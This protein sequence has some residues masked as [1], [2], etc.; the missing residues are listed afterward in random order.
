MTPTPATHPAPEL[1]IV[2]GGAK[3]V[4]RAVALALARAGLDV[5]ITYRSSRDDA[6][7]VVNDIEATG[8]RALAIELDLARP[9]AADT[10]A[11]AIAPL[12]ARVKALVNN[13]AI[14]SPTPL[15]E[16]DADAYD[17]FQALN[18]RAPL[19]LTQR[20]APLLAAGHDPD[21]PATA[22]R[23]V[24]FLD[25]HVM[26]QPR[27]GYAAYSA[28]KAAL[29]ELTHALALEL[30]PAITVNAIAPGVVAWAPGMSDDEKQPYLDRTPLARPGTPDDAAEAV[31]WLTCDA[32]YCTGQIIRVDGGRLL[33]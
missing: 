22:G 19:L 24:N 3:R 20:L 8:R 21:H 12:N 10:L 16:L 1:A 9:D 7:Q 27:P 28:S 31:R 17:T 2:T 5:A 29:L 4:G 30:A 6:Q 26:G 15:A 23:I 11:H 32:H 25:I 18:A 33:G 13:A 14:Y